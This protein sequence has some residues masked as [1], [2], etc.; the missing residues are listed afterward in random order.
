MMGGGN[1]QFS[2]LS[3]APLKNRFSSIT[4]DFHPHLKQQLR[5]GFSKVSKSERKS[6][7]TEHFGVLQKPCNRNATDRRE[8]IIF[9]S[10]EEHCSHKAVL[11][12]RWQW[13]F[14]HISCT[15]SSNADSCTQRWLSKPYR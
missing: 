2:N 5:I 10:V 11:N 13:L 6:V 15:L 7:E 1:Q 3:I 9:P 12:Q 14:I 8:R 4:I